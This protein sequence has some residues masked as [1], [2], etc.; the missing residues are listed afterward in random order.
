MDELCDKMTVIN[1]TPHIIVTNYEQL[2][3]LL[4]SKPE[5]VFEFLINNEDFKRTLNKCVDIT[6]LIHLMNIFSKI[7][8]LELIQIKSTVL[9]MIFNSKYLEHLNNSLIDITK[10]KDLISRVKLQEF[11]INCK[12]ILELTTNSKSKTLLNGII[13]YMQHIL[14]ESN[15]IDIQELLLI[16]DDLKT[17][18]MLKNVV[19]YDVKRWPQC[20]KSLSIYPVIKDITTKKVILS[21]NIIKGSY[22]NI[23]HYIDV[24]FRL[25][26]EDIL[27]P[28]REGIQS[29]RIMNKIDQKCVTK[30]PNMRV[31]FG[32]KITKKDK[33]KETFLVNFFTKE[34]CSINSKR[35]MFNSLLV[36]SDD[37]F[38]SM[39]FAII[40]KMNRKISLPIKT[41]VIQPLGN[42][43]SIKLNSSYTMAESDAYFLPYMYSMDVLKT[44]NLYNF[45]MKSY[46]VYGKSK[47]KVPAYLKYNS[48]IYNINGSQF[49]ILNDKLWPD[50]KVLG[51]DCA[52]KKAFKAALTEEFT[53]I[54]G[55]PGTGKTYI[56]LRIA[57]SII[58]NM[59][60]T[61][62]TN[63]ALDQFLEGLINITKNII[64]IGGGCKSIVLKSHVLAN[65]NNPTAKLSLRNS[66]VVGLTTTGAAMRHSVLLDL[67]PPIVIVEEA[68]EV[69]E[70]H[71]VV[72]LTES[73]QHLILIGDH[74]QLRPRNAS[75][76]LAKR[77]NFDV[78]LFERM[79]KNGFPC[80]TLATQHRMRP[81]ISALMKPIYPFLMD[82]KS[83]NHRSNISGVN[84]N[85]YF[86]HHK[87]PEEKEIG[88]NSHKNIHEVKFFIEFARYLIS[89]GYRQ[90]QITILVTYRDQLLEFQKIQE[91]SFFLEDFRIECVDGYQGE[92]NDIV[93]LSLVR[94]NIDNN[95]GFLH[96]QNR[97]CVALSR[98]RDGLYIMGN[99]D[100]LIHSSIWK[101]I[102]QT[103]VDQQA[104]GNKLTLYC[105]IHKDWINTV[106]N[107]KDF[108]K[109]RCLKVCNIKMDCGHHCPYFCHYN[110]QSHKTLYCCKK[111]YTKI[112]HCGF[113]IKI[114]CW[115]RFLTFECPQSPPMSIRYL[116]TLR[117][118]KKPIL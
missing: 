68:A 64:R 114:E 97:I 78:S 104:L 45:P 58:E 85:I 116:S 21:P 10:L 6:V 56:G 88:S 2:E 24:Q 77:F 84:K 29:Y 30:M 98:A 90:N 39:F 5:K 113:Q 3:L 19:H 73:C 40:I 60:E 41:I 50:N 11:F 108:F 96:I 12:T 32:A 115:M 112:L 89:Q 17:K 28:M 31:Y 46:I 82:H 76:T 67:K 7:K 49:D 65:I 34:D 87:V 20:Y 16:D 107:S 71:I 83:V 38:D 93:L 91:T 92:E 66:Y 14:F 52:Q 53:V 35:F 103:L 37:N 101:K 48:Q 25:L 23:E 63:H 69:L 75:F 74:Q 4:E 109:A 9:E 62:Y 118:S 102:S 105:Q 110:D 51:L 117:K 43:I 111:I 22:D 70:S 47:S 72:S 18:N 79:V 99:M 15:S 80:Y 1:L 59:Y 54:Q 94:S 61:C 8:S 26:R 86:I 81:E 57:R 27:A 55:P 106:C 44:F 100:N 42:K 95:I 33:F 36:F 13:K